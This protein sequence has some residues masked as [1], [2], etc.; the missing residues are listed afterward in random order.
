MQTAAVRGTSSEVFKNSVDVVLGNMVSG[1]GG[2]G[3]T[4]G[5]NDLS[6]LLQP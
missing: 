3:L 2:N 4:V 1:H 5:I 6:G